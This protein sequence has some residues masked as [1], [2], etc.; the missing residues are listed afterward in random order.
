MIQTDF[1]TWLHPFCLLLEFFSEFFDVQQHLQNLIR[2]IALHV[3]A[4]VQL[5]G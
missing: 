2:R 4:P 1:K 3:V 5:L